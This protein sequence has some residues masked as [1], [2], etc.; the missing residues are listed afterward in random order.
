M[1]QG[2]RALDTLLVFLGNTNLYGL[3]ASF[4][5]LI[6]PIKVLCG[7]ITILNT[8]VTQLVACFVLV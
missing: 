7:N 4:M 1:V 3:E 5:M 8:L 6:H 2:S